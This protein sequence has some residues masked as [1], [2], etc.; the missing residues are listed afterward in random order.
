M[1]T[2]TSQRALIGHAAIFQSDEF[3]ATCR[4]V[5]PVIDTVEA[6]K[7]NEVA[8]VAAKWATDHGELLM[9]THPIPLGVDLTLRTIDDGEIPFVVE[10]VLS[11][12]ARGYMIIPNVAESS[13]LGN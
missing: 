11:T 12:P 6:E 5:I 13:Y 8:P 4:F 1:S 9:V 10:S 7:T 2:T 3:L